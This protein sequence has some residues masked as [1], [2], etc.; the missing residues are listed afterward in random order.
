MYSVPPQPTGPASHVALQNGSGTSSA[1]SA[2]VSTA[3]FRC[4]DA[5]SPAERKTIRELSRS[6]TSVEALLSHRL[7][8]HYTVQKAIIEVGGKKQLYFHNCVHPRWTCQ[9]VGGC[10]SK[11]QARAPYQQITA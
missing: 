5:L 8:E 1:S 3:V 2:S 11:S 6:C 10:V 7:N 4:G 9:S